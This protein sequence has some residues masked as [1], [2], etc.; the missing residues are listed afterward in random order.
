VGVENDDVKKLLK[1]YVVPSPKQDLYSG[2]DFWKLYYLLPPEL[3]HQA[4]VDQ[5]ELSDG[6]KVSECDQ[7]FSP[8]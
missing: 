1:L 6:D 2:I 3:N 5:H 8:I 7:L 4:V